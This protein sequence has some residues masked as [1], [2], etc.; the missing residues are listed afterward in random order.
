MCSSPSFGAIE[1]FNVAADGAGPFRQTSPRLQEGAQF[2]SGCRKFLKRPIEV[3]DLAT[4]EMADVITRSAP[5][6]SDTK[7]FSDLDDGEADASCLQDEVQ[8][9]Y[10]FG[11]IYSISR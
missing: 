10:G 3:R 1:A 2:L 9:V 5:R 4:D 8:Q 11:A 6:S 7:D